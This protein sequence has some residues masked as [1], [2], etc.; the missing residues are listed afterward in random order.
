LT[1]G[2]CEFTGRR[3]TEQIE[4]SCA[5]NPDAVIETLSQTI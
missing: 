1:D 5:P 3:D 2:E 4:K